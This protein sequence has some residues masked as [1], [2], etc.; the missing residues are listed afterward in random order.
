MNNNNKNTGPYMNPSKNPNTLP[1]QKKTRE[2]YSQSDNSS[3]IL[4]ENLM[5]IEL[6]ED[7]E[8]NETIIPTIIIGDHE[9]ISNNNVQA[10]ENENQMKWNEQTQHNIIVG[11]N[12]YLNMNYENIN[13]NIENNESTHII[14]DNEESYR[15]QCA[16][17][18]YGQENIIQSMPSEL[19]N[20]YKYS[21]CEDDDSIETD[22]EMDDNTDINQAYIDSKILELLKEKERNKKRQKLSISSE[23]DTSRDVEIIK[24]PKKK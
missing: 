23:D 4:I 6:E 22:K 18:S 19:K 20:V 3:G 17:S 24:K 13:N 21:L 7:K 16:R 12:D 15:E 1:I 11:N 8:N 2:T 5:D 10:Q 9:Q 14:N